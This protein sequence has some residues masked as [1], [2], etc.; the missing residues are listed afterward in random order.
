[1]DVSQLDREALAGYVCE[2][3]KNAGFNVVLTG[4]SCVS[5]LTQEIFVSLDLDFI[6]VG[7]HSNKELARALAEIGFLP[8][9]TNARYFIHPETELPLEFP[10]A[11]LAVGDEVLELNQTDT[12]ETKGGTLRLLTPTDCIKDRLAGYL[13]HN[14]NQCYEQALEVANQ[15]DI[16]WEALRKWC[17]A[18]GEKVLYDKFKKDFNNRYSS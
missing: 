16:K 11:P 12:R 10:S 14:D 9:K 1:M 5:I 2:S 17:N 4:G 8:S 3:L 18:E 6:D 15:Q 13:Y 7:L